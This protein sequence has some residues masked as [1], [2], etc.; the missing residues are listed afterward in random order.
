MSISRPKATTLLRT[1]SPSPSLQR[2]LGVCMDCLDGAATLPLPG[3][4]V[5]MLHFY[6]FLIFST[7]NMY[8]VL[9]DQHYL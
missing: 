2:F 1:R 5:A 3:K 7:L 8:A 4:S 9:L 6:I